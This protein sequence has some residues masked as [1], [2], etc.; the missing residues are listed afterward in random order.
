MVFP[1]VLSR[2]EFRGGGLPDEVVVVAVRGHERL[3]RPYEFE[4]WLR[5]SLAA[6]AS[7][8]LDAPL[9]ERATLL[10]KF[11]EDL[12]DERP[13]H[14]IL[15]EIELVHAAGGHALLR[16]ALVPEYY[17]LLHTRRT[18]AY[19]FT[20][21]DAVIDDVLGR[22]GMAM[23]WSVTSNEAH[24]EEEHLV[25]YRESDAD[26]LARW[27]EREGYSFYFA[28]G[29][30]REELRIT[31]SSLGAEECG[32][33]RYRPLAGADTSATA[34]LTSFRAQEAAQPARVRLRDYDYARPAL[35]VGGDDEV[36]GRG[37]DVVLFEERSFSPD[38]ARRL[39]AV[40]AQ[41]L[42]AAKTTFVGTGTAFGLRPGYVFELE[43]HPRLSGK[44][45]VVR[46]EHRGAQGREALDVA[47]LELPQ[48]YEVTIECIPADVP[49][50]P[51][52]RAAWPRVHGY[53]LGLVDGPADDDYAQLDDEGCYLV[54]LFADESE[55]A[56]D[57][58][59]TRV[60]MMQ[61]HAGSPEGWHFPLRKGTEV[62]VQFLGGDIDRPVIV[63][64][65]PNAVT[66]SVVTSANATENVLQTGGRTRLEIE[67]EKGKQF[68][69][70]STPPAD[71]YLNLGHP[72]HGTHNI[73]LH[74]DK[75]GLYDIGSHQLIEVGGNL[76]E[77]VVSDVTETYAQDQTSTVT[78]P[79]QTTVDNAVSEVYLSTQT[80]TVTG[81]PRT[82]VFDN[83]QLSLVLGAR[84]ERY[85]AS[86]SQHVFGT[87]DELWVGGWTRQSGATTEVHVGNLTEAICGPSM[88]IC[89]AGV[90]EA[91]GPT[92]AVW[93]SLLWI[94]AKL[95]YNAR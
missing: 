42:A 61:P 29:D 81:A 19:T 40:R 65:V 90:T 37:G 20:K 18:R 33:V 83:G 23:P 2:L 46:V 60:R 39:A 76:D 48:G 92:T 86:Q 66:P 21:L 82:E 13:Y 7:L 41:E 88:E 94:G 44:Y 59:S 17:K 45:L 10:V 69:W 87:T 1:G 56:G 32:K 77:Q 5:V 85:A 27:M 67:D 91:Y 95:G 35:T 3:S 49:Y 47:G 24:P 53:Q 4:I 11:G 52:R 93:A 72:E 36:D 71:T 64:A 79:Q 58:V 25:Q 70:L 6:A 16:A 28:H 31:D 74:T 68:I 51:P 57:E 63:G 55:L 9:G 75:D 8:D 54:K 50:R 30:G 43:E 38:D 22:A 34:S 15:R 62:V 84:E 12:A 80:T 89:P 14:G 78:G 26:F 73:T